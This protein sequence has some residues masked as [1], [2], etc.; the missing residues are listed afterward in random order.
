MGLKLSIIICTFNRAER[1]EKCLKSLVGQE[2]SHFEVIIVDGGSTDGTKQVIRQY[3]KK[4]KMRV[5]SSS[6][7]GLVWA[8][9]LGWREAAGQY[10]A[11]IDDDV[12]LTSNW[13]KEVITP[14]DKD[15]KIGGVSGP[16]IIPAK[17]LNHRDVFS[18]YHKKGVWQL[19]GK[20]WQDFFLEGDKYAVGKILKS[21]AW[22]P[23]SN[24]A[25][26]LKLKGLQDV[27][28]LEAC[29]MVLRKA[30][31]SKVN[32]FDLGYSGVSE[33]SEIDLAMRVK[34]LGY[35]LVF[36]PRAVVY[37]HISK[38]GV[39]QRRT[40]ARQRMVN[41]LKFYLGHIFRPRPDYLFKFLA[42]LLFLNAYWGYKAVKTKN[43]NWLGG[44]WGTITGLKYAYSKK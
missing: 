17:L 25:S 31:V 2:F 12:T 22:T 19:I 9:D 44:W 43:L 27:D 26:S 7:P 30:L 21:G 37:H 40:H 20:I 24:F 33:W 39:Y 23:G 5:F 38:G 29:N 32:G 34:K 35:R 3:K 4:L 36:N 13:V 6:R 15:S 11:W 42:Y 41:F 16:T 10:V 8:R 14:L 18:F 1:L 28:Y